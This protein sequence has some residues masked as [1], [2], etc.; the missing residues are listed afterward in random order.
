MKI[1]KPAGCLSMR[2]TQGGSPEQALWI[3]IPQSR[4]A[5]NRSISLSKSFPHAPNRLQ[6][7]LQRTRE[8]MIEVLLLIQPAQPHEASFHA[9]L[10]S[11]PYKTVRVS[12]S[13]P[14]RICIAEHQQDLA[15]NTADLSS[16]TSQNLTRPSINQNGVRNRTM[17]ENGHRI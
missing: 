12:P 16:T 6:S 4:D 10:T 7:R 3:R 17:N 13:T 9:I 14:L 5:G 8:R 1:I 15:T 11:P 2:H